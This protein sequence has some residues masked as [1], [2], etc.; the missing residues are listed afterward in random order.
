M[1]VNLLS[2]LRDEIGRLVRPG[3]YGASVLANS[4]PRSSSTASESLRMLRGFD[5]EQGLGLRYAVYG[6]SRYGTAR[7]SGQ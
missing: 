6:R 4:R 5:H 3:Q 7:Y 1:S 2:V